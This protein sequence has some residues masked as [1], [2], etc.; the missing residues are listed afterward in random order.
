MTPP[1]WETTQ[2]V[3]AVMTYEGSA[4]SGYIPV[5]LINGANGDT[6]RGIAG[7]YMGVGLQFGQIQFGIE[8][9]GH[10]NGM[11]SNIGFTNVK[12]GVGTNGDMSMGAPG[13][14][15][16]LCIGAYQSSPSDRYLT[17]VG[18]SGSADCSGFGADWQ[19]A[20][21]YLGEN[22]DTNMGNVGSY[23]QI[24]VQY[25][26]GALNAKENYQ[27]A[28]DKL[29]GKAKVTDATRA[30]TA[31]AS[32][33]QAELKVQAENKDTAPTKKWQKEAD[34]AKKSQQGKKTGKH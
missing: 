16:P 23:N 7:P 18:M 15:N 25:A 2:K 1:A 17:N 19:P 27:S 26:Y 5:G 13:N 22:G 6:N 11:C 24:C 4:Y 8:T 34:D 32:K 12:W 10:V 28:A 29:A 3:T 9:L 33:Q 20:D 14:Y 21:L 31:L 30:A